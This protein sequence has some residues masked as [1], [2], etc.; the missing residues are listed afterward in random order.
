MFTYSNHYTEGDEDH[1]EEQ[2]LKITNNS[3]HISL[4]P[5]HS[6]LTF[7]SRGTAREVGGIIS[8][9][10]RKNTVSERRIEMERL[11]FSPESEGR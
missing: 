3:H 7:P 2:I 1:G 11:T 8:A 4:S 10:S 9:R 6:C 5:R